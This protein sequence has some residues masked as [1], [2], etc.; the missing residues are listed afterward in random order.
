MFGCS[1]FSGS[2]FK[3]PKYKEVRLSNGLTVLLIKD[4]KLPSFSMQML[5]KAGSSDDPV[6]KSGLA[7]F[8]GQML[9]KGTI[10]R[11]A[12][13]IADDLGQLGA[14]FDVSVGLDYTIISSSSLSYHKDFLI[15]NFS[16]V[17][18]QPLFSNSE[19][20]RLK[21]Q[22]LA[23]IQN[24]VD[25]PSYLANVAFSSYLYGAHP[26]GKRSEG[27]SK[28]VKSIKKKNIIR[29]YRKYYRPNNAILAVIGKFDES[30]VD[31]LE[32]GLKNWTA[33][34]IE[35]ENFP[36]LNMADSLQL[37]LVNKPGLKQSQ[38]RIGEI[39]IDR[40]NKDFLNLRI[41]NSILGGAFYSRLMQEV[42]KKRGLTYSISSRFDA[43]KEEGP[44]TIATFTRNDKVGETVKAT[45]DTL[46]QFKEKGVSKEEVEMAKNMIIGQFPRAIETSEKLA[47]NLLILRFYGIPDSYL[48]NFVA[49]VEDISVADVNQAIKE[50]IDTNKLKVLVFSPK[51]TA[52]KQLRDIGIVEVKDYK[53]F[54]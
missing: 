12:L 37:Q 54:L 35:K 34:K 18:T 47:F 13:K 16:E 1:S 52:L 17:L 38:I 23:G 48:S 22:T 15:D 26:Y 46:K 14:D 31:Q 21:T 25:H 50:H 40:H 41:A 29:F 51:A 28:D 33:Q 24:S 43:L 6:T 11:N 7:N 49:N 44:F 53:E 5:V 32:S 20:N 9:D 8:T 39:G 10:K 4:N 2:S 45:I 3:L 42:R 27:S 30:I 36:K 19:I